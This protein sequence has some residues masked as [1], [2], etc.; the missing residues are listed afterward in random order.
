MLLP[1]HNTR[2]SSS[3]HVSPLLL[4]GAGV[5]SAIVSTSTLVRAA[6][7]NSNIRLFAAMEGPLTQTVTLTP[8]QLDPGQ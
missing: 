8:L 6:G 2:V 7:P 5:R 3:Q 4:P 1:G